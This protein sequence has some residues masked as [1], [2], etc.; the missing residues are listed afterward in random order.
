M[1]LFD[2]SSY[3]FEGVVY[4]AGV[5]YILQHLV[6]DVLGQGET[7]RQYTRGRAKTH[8]RLAQELPTLRSHLVLIVAT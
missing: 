4:L 6:K 1:L 2:P 8:R 3:P 5:L 7:P